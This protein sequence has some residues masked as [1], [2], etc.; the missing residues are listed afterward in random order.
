MTACAVIWDFDWSLVNENTDTW[1]FATQ[2]DSGVREM[3]HLKARSRAGAQWTALMDEMLARR[4][5]QRAAGCAPPMSRLECIHV[6]VC[7]V[8][9]K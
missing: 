3:E 1:V 5:Q 4:V 6:Y 2:P 8:L 7:I 9:G